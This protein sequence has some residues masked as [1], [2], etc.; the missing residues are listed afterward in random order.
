MLTSANRLRA[1]GLVLGG[2]LLASGLVQADAVTDWNE[3]AVT[4]VYAARHSPDMQS[5]CLALMHIAMFEAVNSIEARYTPYRAR[6]P[7]EPGALPEAAAAA[8]AHAVLVKLIPDQA[9]EFDATLQAALGKLPDGAGK[10]AG[11][12]LGAQSAAAI[13]AE[14]EKDGADAPI[15]YR[16]FTQPGK[17]VPTQFPASSTWNALQPFVM[18]SGSQFRP[19]A[20]Y[21]LSDARWAADYNEV[22]RMGAKNGAMR[23]PEQTDIARFWQLTGTATY[24]PVTRHVAAVKGLGLIDNARLFALSSIA[25]ADTAIAIFDAKYAYNFWRPVTAI[26]NGDTDGND[27]TALEAGWEPFINTP[28]HP[29]YPCAHCTFQAAAAGILQTLYG[30]TVPRFT[31][32]SAVAPGITRSYDRL[33]DYVTEVINARIYEGVHY[34]TSG[35][36]GAAMGRRI[37]EY[38][39]ANHLKPAP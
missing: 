3:K 10:A 6:L 39:V 15:T 1:C 38:V 26:R 5:R 37:A 19:P 32:T 23:S 31:L 35:E 24:N 11:I 30:D 33:S 18:K 14:R 36:V 4:A 20:P 2:S 27:A 16:P 9:K 7:V 28:M 21:A 29:E 8:A 17:Y 34:R 12:R 22:K 25:S 13:L